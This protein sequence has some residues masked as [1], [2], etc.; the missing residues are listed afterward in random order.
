MCDKG[1][2]GE[3]FTFVWLNGIAGSSGP[4]ATVSL[5]IGVHGRH[6]AGYDEPGG[7]VTIVQ[8]ASGGQ[9]EYYFCSTL[10][11]RAFFTQCVDE[12]DAKVA[13]AGA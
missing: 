6:D 3:P 2:V 5:S 13:A 7:N 10:C 12:L 8:D 4:S 1:G 9:F 11:L